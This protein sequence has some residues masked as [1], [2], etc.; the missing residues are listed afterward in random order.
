MASS[1]IDFQANE[2]LQGL[3]EFDEHAL[4]S[5][6]MVL[7]FWASRAVTQ[8]RQNATWTDRTG[9]AR[10]GLAADV[11]AT[12]TGGSLVLYHTVPYGIWLEIRW[13]GRYAIVGPTLQEIG[14]QLMAMLAQA[15]GGGSRV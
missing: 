12:G 7:Q 3:D 4:Q 2:L 14:P 8:M 6:E 1:G 9:N 15:I 13:S 11:Q 5:V 10:N